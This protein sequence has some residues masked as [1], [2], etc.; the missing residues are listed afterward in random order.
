MLIYNLFIEFS[1]NYINRILE[2][3]KYLLLLL[4]PYLLKISEDTQNSQTMYLFFI[5]KTHF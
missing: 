5:F 4:F 2:S 1:R 3:L